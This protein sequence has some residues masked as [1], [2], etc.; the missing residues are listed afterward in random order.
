M[1][2]EQ[3]LSNLRKGGLLSFVLPEAFLNVKTHTPIRKILLKCSNFQY[4]E[5]LG[6]VFDKVQCPCII[7]QV[8]F[9]N[10]IFSSIGTKICVG[11]REYTINTERAV[12]EEC[13]S[14]TITDEEYRVLEKMDGLK[15][16][17]TLLGKARFALGIVTG[18]NKDI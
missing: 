7:L 11:T 13:M 6:N 8:L 1:F 5:Y 12:N 15:Q 2:V 18:N 4:I 17:A 10:T 14:F 3:G 9:T 16:K